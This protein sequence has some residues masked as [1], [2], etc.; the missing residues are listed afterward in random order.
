[1]KSFISYYFGQTLLCSSDLFCIFYESW[2]CYKTLLRFLNRRTCDQSA[3]CVLKSAFLSSRVTLQLAAYPTLHLLCKTTS[4]LSAE[5]S[6]LE[7]GLPLPSDRMVGFFSVTS[8]LDGEHIGDS[9][10]R[11]HNV[12]LLKLS[13]HFFISWCVPDPVTRW[14]YV[15]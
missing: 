10:E 8:T 5:N 12:L 2:T 4:G 13:Q 14:Y 7:L 11:C 9:P 1:M 3:W 15:L 6:L